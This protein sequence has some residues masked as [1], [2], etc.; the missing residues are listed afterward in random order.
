L[1]ARWVTG[2]FF[3]LFVG[4]L[5]IE[6]ILDLLLFTSKTDKRPNNSGARVHPALT[7]FIERFFFTIVVGLVGLKFHGILSGMMAWLGLK[8]AAN[9]NRPEPANNSNSEDKSMKNTRSLVAL[10]AG[11]ISMLFALIGGLICAG[12]TDATN[13]LPLIFLVSLLCYLFHKMG[14]F[15]YLFNKFLQT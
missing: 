6:P 11:L 12:V 14:W 2:L 4:Y 13:W 9:W 7:G 10:L 8:L 5:F 3:S 15:R 1:E